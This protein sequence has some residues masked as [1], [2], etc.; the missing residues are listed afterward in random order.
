MLANLDEGVPEIYRY[1]KP[2]TFQERSYIIREG[3]P[4]DLMLFITQGFVW[5]FGGSGS[6]TSTSKRLGA[7]DYH[8]D[9]LLRWILAKN[10]TQNQNTTELMYCDFPI[11]NCNVKSSTKVEAFAIMA[12]DLEE[13]V[14]KFWWKFHPNTE[15]AREALAP[16]AAMSLQAQLRRFAARKKGGQIISESEPEPAVS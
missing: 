10:Q 2:M 6:S 5:T 12:N 1:L 3:E 14:V 7:G 4:L 11:S 16:F 15:D 13:L 8:G 9:E